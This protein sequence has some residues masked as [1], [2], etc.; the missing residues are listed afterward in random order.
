MV[1]STWYQYQ[2]QVFHGPLESHSGTQTVPG[3]IKDGFSIPRKQ[4]QRP[5]IRKIATRE[6]LNILNLLLQDLK[7]TKLDAHKIWH[8]D[9]PDAGGGKHSQKS[10][11]KENKSSGSQTSG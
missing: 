3:V 4:I 6:Q 7:E 9:T 2:T 1:D 11:Q 5:S 8:R 10:P